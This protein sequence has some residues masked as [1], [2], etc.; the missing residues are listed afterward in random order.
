MNEIIKTLHEQDHI[1]IYATYLRVSAK[2]FGILLKDVEVFIKS[3]TRCM[4]EKLPEMIQSI[5]P[6][7]PDYV[8]E[9]ILVDTV[10]LSA[11][12]AYNINF[13]YMF[14][15]VDYFSKYAWA[16]P[17]LLKDARSFSLIFR[18]IFIKKAPC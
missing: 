2:Y 4:Q 12:S 10:D 8:R 1:G 3:C 18:D 5:T 13:R 17:S 15:M 11:Y 9:R 16:Y 6:I 7:L 14:V